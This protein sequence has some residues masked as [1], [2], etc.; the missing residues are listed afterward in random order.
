MFRIQDRF[1]RLNTFTHFIR[2]LG[3]LRQTLLF[4]LRQ[5]APG[6]TVAV[7]QPQPN[8]QYEQHEN[9]QRNGKKKRALR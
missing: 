2:L 9:G 6:R 8:R 7:M 3:Q 5:L 4:A 1:Q